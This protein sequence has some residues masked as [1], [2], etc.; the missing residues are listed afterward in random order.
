MQAIF[1][2]VLIA[3]GACVSYFFALN[4]PGDQIVTSV[5]GGFIIG[6]G[7]GNV[8]IWASD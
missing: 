6:V 4:V 3:I 5:C 1:G 2:A 7:L 8:L